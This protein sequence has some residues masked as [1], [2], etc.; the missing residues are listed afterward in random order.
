MQTFNDFQNWTEST[1]IY[2]GVTYPRLALAEEV[3]ELLGKLAKFERD[4]VSTVVA[5]DLESYVVALQKLRADVTKEAG[6]VLWQLARV[7]KDLDIPMQDAV[8]VNVAKLESRKERNVL[9]GSGDDR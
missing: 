3:G 7:L 5:L 8:D 6:D 9:N 4:V 2:N 1:A